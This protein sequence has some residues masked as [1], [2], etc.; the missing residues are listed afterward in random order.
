M[1]LV[2]ITFVYFLFVVVKVEI[3]AKTSSKLKKSIESH[4]SQFP[5]SDWP[6]NNIK[7]SENKMST[8]A[9]RYID[10]VKVSAADDVDL[11]IKAQSSIKEALQKF[12]DDLCGIIDGNDKKKLES[13]IEKAKRTTKLKIVNIAIR[14]G[15]S[16]VMPSLPEFSEKSSKSAKLAKTEI[17]LVDVWQNLSD[18][19]R[20]DFF[21]QVEFMTN[22]VLLGTIAKLS[23]NGEREYCKQQVKVISTK[24]LL[25][26]WE[27]RLKAQ[28][29]LLRN[30]QGFADGKT[31][32]KYI[33]EKYAKWLR[34]HSESMFRP[35]EYVSYINHNWDSN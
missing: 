8:F 28:L 20:Q 10:A 7:K 3:L 15:V 12:T 4:E 1:R 21:D 17:E 35:L 25:E 22:D 30:S 26:N 31:Y 13:S 18:H 11:K 33:R 32:M 5:N 6:Y 16:F 9:E 2:H 19:T 14:A 24:Y 23:T 27:T 34:K 29:K